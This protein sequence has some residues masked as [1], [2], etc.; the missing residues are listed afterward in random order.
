MHITS[1][2]QKQSDQLVNVIGN[3]Q[4]ITFVY[5]V[6]LTENFSP[7]LWLLEISELKQFRPKII[8]IK[9]NNVFEFAADEILSVD[10]NDNLTF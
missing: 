8:E 4:T 5:L 6:N 9:R 10:M 2:I 3:V 7:E 1:E